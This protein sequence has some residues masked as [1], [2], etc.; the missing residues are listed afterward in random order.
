M[1]GWEMRYTG[2]KGRISCR[3]VLFVRQE[4]Y[5]IPGGYN[6]WCRERHFICRA[7]Y[8]LPEESYF[9][10]CLARLSPQKPGYYIRIA[11]FYQVCKFF[12]QRKAS[13]LPGKKKGTLSYKP[14][15][16]AGAG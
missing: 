12:R 7:F 10:W 1:K 8:F 9:T 13:H 5:F 15:G 16:V 3:E 6:I 14:Y 11:I 2:W 4:S